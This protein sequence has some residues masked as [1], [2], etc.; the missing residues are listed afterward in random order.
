MIICSLANWLSIK[1]SDVRV[2]RGLSIAD[3]GRG[4]LQLRASKRTRKR[5]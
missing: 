3:K 2:E 4:I 1:D 5:N